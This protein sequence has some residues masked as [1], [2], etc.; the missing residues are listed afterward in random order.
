MRIVRRAALLALAV[1]V[2]TGGVALAAN[3][4]KGSYQGDGVSFDV[5][6]HSVSGLHAELVAQC[7]GVSGPYGSRVVL[8][9]STV[10]EL[11]RDGRFAAVLQT[12]EADFSQT[13][14]VDARFVDATHATGTI[15][16]QLTDAA[17]DTCDTGVKAFSAALVPR[18]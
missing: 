18:R 3:A 14:T 5:A 11:G 15:R 13:I 12:D 9:P 8:S 7:D 10:F 2:V 4:R 1:M 16:W 6:K 17:G